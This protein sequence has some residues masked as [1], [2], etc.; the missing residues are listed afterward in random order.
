MFSCYIRC[1]TARLRFASDHSASGEAETVC[2]LY[3]K[4]LVE[5]EE[6]VLFSGFIGL[7]KSVENYVE[8]V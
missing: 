7:H 8:N 3:A 4:S 6:R 2:G 1:L 5:V